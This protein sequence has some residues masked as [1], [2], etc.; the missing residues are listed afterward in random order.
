LSFSAFFLEVGQKPFSESAPRAQNSHIL[1]IEVFS[2]RRE[3]R[4]L[5]VVQP[6]VSALGKKNSTTTLFP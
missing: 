2:S 4:T 5:S 6:G 3:T 1:F